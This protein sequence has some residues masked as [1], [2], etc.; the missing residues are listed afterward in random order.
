MHMKF[1]TN[2]AFWEMFKKR[3]PNSASNIQPQYTEEMQTFSVDLYDPQIM[4]LDQPVDLESSWKP[5]VQ[6]GK[7]YLQL[8]KEKLAIL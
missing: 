4:K 3:S 5:W 7:G 2:L 6:M 8:K 1:T